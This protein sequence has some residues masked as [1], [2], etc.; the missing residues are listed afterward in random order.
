MGFA[1]QA[2]LGAVFISG[3]L[4]C[5]DLVPGLR[6]LIVDG[7]PPSMRTAITVGIGLFLAPHRAE[8]RRP[9]GGQSRRPGHPGRPAQARAV[10]AVVGFLLIVAA[11]RPRVRGA[12][13]WA[14]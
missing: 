8:E 14:S 12:L 13:C 9:R 1:W 11:R 2:A 5:A 10:L 3:C 4:F 7:I 6:E